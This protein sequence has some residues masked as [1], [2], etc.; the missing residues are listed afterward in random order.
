MSIKLCKRLLALNVN[1]ESW[2]PMIA[3]VVTSKFDTATL[4]E[5]ERTTS[6]T[7]PTTKKELLDFLK[8]KINVLES[9]EDRRIDTSKDENKKTKTAV[10]SPMKRRTQFH[11]FVQHENKK[12]KKSSFTHKKCE[13]CSG[14]HPLHS[15]AMY[16]KI[17]VPDRMVIVNT[18]SLCRVCLKK[19]T[20]EC[21]RQGCTICGRKHH[22]LLHQ[23]SSVDKNKT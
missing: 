4:T 23:D 8:K 5:W 2:H 19:H 11:S 16:G 12:S 6:S 20:G 22:N 10:A 3:Y 15:C 1:T 18:Q 17:S 9:V 14:L 7:E 13:Y 21:Y